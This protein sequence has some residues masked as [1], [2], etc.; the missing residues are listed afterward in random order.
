MVWLLVYVSTLVLS[1]CFGS[2]FAKL[3]CDE[4]LTLFSV[5]ILKHVLQPYRSAHVRLESRF[6]REAKVGGDDGCHWF[7]YR[8]KIRYAF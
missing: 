7:R 1:K 2:E 5:P 8:V 6:G 4:F 3:L